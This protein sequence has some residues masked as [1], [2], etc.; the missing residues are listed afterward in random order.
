M[1]RAL[2][3]ELLL[4]E[5]TNAAVRTSKMLRTCNVVPRVAARMPP[6][7][8]S[9]H[10]SELN[11]SSLSTSRS[12]ESHVLPVISAFHGSADAAESQSPNEEQEEVALLMHLLRSVLELGVKEEW[13]HVVAVRPKEVVFVAARAVQTAAPSAAVMLQVSTVCCFPAYQ[14]SKFG[15]V[16]LYTNRL[17]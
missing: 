5:A 9:T 2:Q 14:S 16:A 1:R 17:Q 12:R 10:P 6:G 7:R 8:P 3:A 11:G 13:R 15:A 4:R